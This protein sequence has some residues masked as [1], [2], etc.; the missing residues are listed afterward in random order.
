MKHSGFVLVRR[1]VGRVA[2][3]FITVLLLSGPALSLKAQPLLGPRIVFS[4]FHKGQ[5]DIFSI[6]PTGDDLRQLNNSIYEDTDPALSPDGAKLAY[7]SRR[8]DNWDI[9]ILD[10]STGDETRLTDHPHYDGRPAWHPD[11][12]SLAFES[13]RNG[14]LDI[15]I[16]DIAPAGDL[17][18]ITADSDAGDFD[19]AWG[20]QGEKLFFVSWREGNNDL[21]VYEAES[22]TLT[23]LTAD[24]ASDSQPVWNS[25][26]QALAFTRNTLGD[27]DLWLS[28]LSASLKLRTEP[29]EVTGLGDDAAPYTWLGSVSQPAFSP[30]GKSI[31]AIWQGYDGARLVRLDEGNPSP[32][33]LTGKTLLQGSISWHPEAVISGESLDHLGAPDPSPLYAETLTPSASPHGEPY[34]FVKIPGLWASGDPW[35]A[36]TVD[37]SY[38][39][40]RSRVQGEVGYDF[41]GRVSETLRAIDYF[42][43]ASQYSSW[44][45]SGRAVDTLLDL[46][47]NRLEI[48]REDIGGETYWRVLLRCQDQSGRCGRPITANAWNYSS[49]ARTLIAPEQ[50]GIER[51][52]E[53]AYYLDFTT[54]ALMYGW[55]RISSYDDEDFSWTW[56]FKAF[57]YWHY[58]KSLTGQNGNHTWYQAMLQ[59]Y[60]QFEVDEYFTWPQ[61]RAADEDPYVVALK[62]VPLPPD[63]QRWWQKLAANNTIE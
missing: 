30:N 4:A 14:D 9:Y 8:D 25:K 51:P 61:M 13:Y 47:E 52:N 39:A 15:W 3:I 22:E 43:D 38:R 53:S 37:E 62:G 41:L 49:R 6:S 58:Q 57:E 44:H 19:P 5:W 29:A 24:P 21:W 48:V 45:K 46:P 34:D 1:F 42:T 26:K 2:P 7:A 60:P 11:G 12:E 36:D 55:T 32:L 35:L 10:L 20:D 50:G 27:K 31:A 63:A 23:R 28:N 59:V 16:S 54:L 56:H 17:Q 33:Y 40:L 18:N